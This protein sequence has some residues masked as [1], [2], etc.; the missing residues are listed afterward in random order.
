[1]N[2]SQ[3]T[4]IFPLGCVISGQ[5]TVQD[6]VL[7]LPA[8]CPPRSNMDFGAALCGN[9]RA[10]VNGEL[11]SHGALLP[12]CVTSGNPLIQPNREQSTPRRY[13]MAIE[14][15]LERVHEISLHETESSHDHEKEMHV[16]EYLTQT[17]AFFLNKSEGMSDEYRLYLD[18]Q[19]QQLELLSR[20]FENQS[21]YHRFSRGSIADIEQSPVDFLS[22]LVSEHEHHRYPYL[23]R[24]FF[25]RSDVSREF[26][27][28][29]DEFMRSEPENIQS[30][31]WSWVGS[32]PERVSSTYQLLQVRHDKTSIPTILHQPRKN[33]VGLLIVGVNH[34]SLNYLPDEEAWANY[35]IHFLKSYFS[36][37]QRQHQNRA[38]DQGTS[39]VDLLSIADSLLDSLREQIRHSAQPVVLERD[40]YRV[41][42]FTDGYFKAWGLQGQGRACRNEDGQDDD[43]GAATFDYVAIHGVPKKI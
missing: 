30:Q 38:H 35:R 14:R 34:F 6:R 18:Y 12:V 4:I 26:L 32:Q 27:R 40:G 19:R 42:I 11:E 16:I 5:N 39:G 29:R 28:G 8:L 43:G 15:D 13:E 21:S 17:T 24:E 20:R 22:R 41:Q 3:K 9:V 23:H 2:P 10:K 7:T 25:R 31:L 1:M 37:H 36:S 33:E